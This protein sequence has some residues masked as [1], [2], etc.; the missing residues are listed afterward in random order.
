MILKKINAVLGLSIIAALIC[1]GGTMT[2][3]LITYWYNYTICKFF[4]HAAVVLMI[5]HALMSIC[6]FF[7]LH[8]GSSISYSRLNTSTLIQRITAVLM[9]IFIHFHTTAY[10]HM[11]TGESLSAGKTVFVLITEYIYIIS[12]FLHTSVSF[13]KAL[14]TLGLISSA[15][16]A[17]RVDKAAYI[18][19]GV[20]T[21]GALYGITAFFVG[22]LL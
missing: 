20:F 10:A 16:T 7:F 1:H 8:D 18:I 2:Y 5:L 3:S 4:A 22:G 14:I 19:C 12:V 15:K 17:R 6:I 11:A 9:I 21:L 13:S